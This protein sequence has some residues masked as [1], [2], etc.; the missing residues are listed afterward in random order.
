MEGGVEFESYLCWRFFP[1]LFKQSSLCL[2]SQKAGVL[3]VTRL[4]VARTNPQI[5]VERTVIY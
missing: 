5:L 1:N 4:A 3:V 2:E